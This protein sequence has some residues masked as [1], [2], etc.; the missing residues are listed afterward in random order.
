MFKSL[1][2]KIWKSS[3]LRSNGVLFV[4]NI[5]NGIVNFGI[6]F[7]AEFRLSKESF[8]LWVAISGAVSVFQ[9]PISGLSTHLVRK[10]ANLDHTNQDV[11]FSYYSQF[12]LLIIKLVGI[13]LVSSPA[14]GLL[15]N[16]I[17]NYDDIFSSWL[18]IAYISFQFLLST[19]QQILLGRLKVWRYAANLLTYAFIRLSLTVGLILTGFGVPTLPLAMLIAAVLAFILGEWLARPV[20]AELNNEKGYNL[21]PVQEFSSTFWTGAVLQLLLIFMNLG[22]LTGKSF[23]SKEDL[24][25]YSLAYSFGQI[26][27]FGASSALGTFVSHSARKHNK[28][29]YFYTLG[30]M[31]S[32][33]LVI[34]TFVLGGIGFGKTILEKIGKVVYFD[35]LKYIALFLLFICFYNAIYV[36]IQYLLSRSAFKKAGTIF[37]FVALQFVS[38]FTLNYLGLET[39]WTTIWVNVVSSFLAAVTLI[40]LAFTWKIDPKPGNDAVPEIY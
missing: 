2:K 16:Y 40:Y 9:G 32:L 17:F 15:I 12:K 38:L 35:N 5:I 11:L 37:I 23:L 25:S 27:H 14:L 6:I 3:F 24:Y 4:A 7:F 29:L 36:T 34:S 10:I 22:V 30:I 26:V 13:L 20:L 31:M 39:A 19:N 1:G 18:I 33:S 8:A 28:N 21:K